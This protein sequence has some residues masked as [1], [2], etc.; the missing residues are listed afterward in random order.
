VLTRIPWSPD[1]TLALEGGLLVNSRL[2]HRF[3][4][5]SWRGML[6]T[7]QS[8]RLDDLASVAPRFDRRPFEVRSSAN[9]AAG[10]NA[11]YDAIVRLPARESDPEIPVG[12]V[13][14]AYR[15]VQ[16]WEV[17]EHV[18]RALGE[19]GVDRES[20][21]CSALLTPYGERMA[22]SVVFPDDKRFR[23][24]LGE[25]DSMRL[26]I[27]CFNSVDRSTRFIVLVG[28]LRFVCLNGLVVGKT[29]SH[30]RRAHTAA[31]DLDDIGPI[32]RRGVRD[33]EGE[34]GLW[35]HWRSVRVAP[36][37]LRR[38]ADD[39]LKK[40]WGVKAAARVYSICS[41]GMDLVLTKPFENAAPSQ[42]S[43]TLG[44]RVPG[45]ATPSETAFDVAQAL[46][47]FG[48]QRNDVTARL[49]STR[50]IPQLVGALVNRIASSRN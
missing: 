45:A 36:G 7:P 10:A 49:Q 1:V 46:S 22:L 15:L 50:E 2:E 47:W 40:R 38:W 8:G 41:T 29:L 18:G 30:L 16:H 28:W 32:V 44:S 35:D 21:R 9:R 39:A 26:R 27:E 42:R 25:D 23:Y 24:L 19:S 48:G 6:L 14:R 13:S 3:N 17:I 31:L 43:G 37:E 12:I 11:H 4:F 33:A 5:G 20:V 34:R